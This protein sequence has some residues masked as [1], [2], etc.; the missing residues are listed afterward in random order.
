MPSDPRGVSGPSRDSWAPGFTARASLLGSV[1][2][3]P[4]Q[5]GHMYAQDPDFSDFHCNATHIF[6]GLR[7]GKNHQQRG[8][9][10][11]RR[12]RPVVTGTQTD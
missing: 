11:W 8:D 6:Q 1:S 10:G 4:Q 5:G 12:K 7:G 3:G 9:N 2:A